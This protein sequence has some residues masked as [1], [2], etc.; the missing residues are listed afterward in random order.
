M[1]EA[2]GKPGLEFLWNLRSSQKNDRDSLQAFL[3]FGGTLCSDRI[4]SSGLENTSDATGPTSSFCPNGMEDSCSLPWW[5]CRMARE[6]S[7]LISGGCYRHTCI[8]S[9]AS[10]VTLCDLTCLTSVSSPVKW[11]SNGYPVSCWYEP[12]GCAPYM[13]DA[14]GPSQWIEPFLILLRFW[15]PEPH[16]L[17]SSAFEKSRVASVSVPWSP[18]EGRPHLGLGGTK[19]GEVRRSKSVWGRGSLG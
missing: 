8:R 14:I 1:R 6:N 17:C 9:P 16:R 11:G 12:L 15:S 19:L 13:A 3:V 2:V 7:F 4:F 18:P 10:H 5:F